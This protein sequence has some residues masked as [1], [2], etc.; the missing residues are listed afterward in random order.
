V[1]ARE[2][3]RA[4]S[5][6]ASGAGGMMGEMGSAAAESAPATTPAAEVVAAAAEQGTD[7]DRERAKRIRRAA[8]AR[9]AENTRKEIE[10]VRNGSHPEMT[11]R[12]AALEK[13]K[14]ARLAAAEKNLETHLSSYK[15]LLEAELATLR[16]HYN[17][18]IEK[19]KEELS[20]K[21][22]AELKRLETAKGCHKDK[23]EKSGNGRGGVST[24]NLRSKPRVEEEYLEAVM[25]LSG[26]RGT[27]GRKRYTS[28]IVCNMDRRLDDDE[29][30][31]DFAFLAED[32]E[33]M[34]FAKRS[35]G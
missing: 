9:R 32:T 20:T 29:I 35:R 34:R 4:A 16:R 25:N 26:V 28:T 10:R 12:C 30:E 22:L 17:D 33:N 15:G 13:K 7:R 2:G 11:R 21:L 31:E 8:F 24:R 1:A 14:Q 18:A 27:S 5:E 3:G 6:E 19:A 23:D